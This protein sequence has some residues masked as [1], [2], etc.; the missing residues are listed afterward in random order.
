[1]GVAGTQEGSMNRTST[2]RSSVACSMY[3]MPSVPMTL[4]ISW[5]SVMTV[6]VPWGSTARAN[7]L[8]LTSELSRWMWAS[9]KPGSTIL[10]ETSTST[11]P[12]YSPMPTIKPS[13]T[14]ISA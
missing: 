11:L 14:A 6:V 12:W 5:G 7:S 9:T 8:G 1:M 4:A 2:G 10:P 3:S 13:A